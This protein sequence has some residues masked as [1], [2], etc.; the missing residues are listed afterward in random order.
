MTNQTN[1]KPFDCI[2][3]KRRVQEGIYEKIKDMTPQ[4][5]IEYFRRG[6]ETGPFAELVRTL[7]VRQSRDGQGVVLSPDS[8]FVRHNEAQSSKM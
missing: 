5:E 6:A 4:E 7:R 2:E 3:Y 1:D 8:K